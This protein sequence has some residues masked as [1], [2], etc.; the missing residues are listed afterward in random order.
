MELLE[1]IVGFPATHND[2]VFGCCM[3]NLLWIS[4]QIHSEEIYVYVL[5]LLLDSFTLGPLC[6]PEV[7]NSDIKSATCDAHRV[8]LHC[9]TDHPTMPAHHVIALYY[10]MW[11]SA[12]WHTAEDHII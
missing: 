12:V 10:M 9:M 4:T 8:F 2:A 6:L 3:W 5:S 11:S 7:T 1:P